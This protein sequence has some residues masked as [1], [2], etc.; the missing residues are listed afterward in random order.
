MRAVQKWS[1]GAESMGLVDVPE[2]VVGPDDLLI[3]VGAVGICGSDIHLWRD[4]HEPCIPGHEYSGLIIGKGEH[5]G[6][7]WQMGERICGDLDV[8]RTHRYPRQW[9]LCRAHDVASAFGTQASRQP[10]LC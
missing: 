4:E 3:E 7:E 10:G 5:I 2:A 1:Y 8:V 6:D 9:G